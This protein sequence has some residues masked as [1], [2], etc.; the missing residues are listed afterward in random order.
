MKIPSYYPL[1]YKNGPILRLFFR[2]S[3]KKFAISFVLP[4]NSFHL[5]VTYGIYQS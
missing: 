5:V 3:D 4:V 2:I 1:H